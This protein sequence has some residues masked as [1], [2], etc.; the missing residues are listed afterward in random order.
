VLLAAAAYD[1]VFDRCVDVDGMRY[2]APSQ[3]VVDLLTGPGRSP[4]EGQALL[5]WMEG[6]EDAWRR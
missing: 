2:A 6:D 1:V 4:S 5:E 3:V